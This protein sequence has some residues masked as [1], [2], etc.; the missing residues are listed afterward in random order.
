M[1]QCWGIYAQVGFIYLFKRDP[2]EAAP[3]AIASSAEK[4]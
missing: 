3:D 1:E 2:E 4:S